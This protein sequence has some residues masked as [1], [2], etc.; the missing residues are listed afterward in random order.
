MQVDEK[1]IQELIN[2]GNARTLGEQFSARAEAMLSSLP[3]A[4]SGG[5]LDWSQIP[6]ADELEWKY[7]TDNELVEWAKR[8]TAGQ[9]QYGLILY[10]SNEPC[11]IAPFEFAIRK[12]DEFVWKAPG[13]RLLYGVSFCNE[14]HIEISND[15]IEFDGQGVL[16]GSM[17]S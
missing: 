5:I 9:H 4:I 1:H 16:Y 10:N 17:K 3:L 11:I 14:D 7:A 6:N 12:F 2:S 15:V 8:T 13:P